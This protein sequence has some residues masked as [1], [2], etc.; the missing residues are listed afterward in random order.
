MYLATLA[1]ILS[2][3]IL[4]SCEEL[5]VESSQSLAAA[6]KNVCK[7]PCRCDN[8]NDTL[9]VDPRDDYHATC[10]DIRWNAK[11]KCSTTYSAVTQGGKGGKKG[12]RDNKKCVK[13]IGACVSEK[14]Q[15][16][17]Q[18]KLP[19]Y[20]LQGCSLPK[21]G[22]KKVRVGVRLG[23]HQERHLCV[24]EAGRDGQAMRRGLP[25]RLL[26]A[27]LRGPRARLQDP[28]AGR[29]GTPTML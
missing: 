27:M 24:L 17:P 13:A 28:R 5:S 9:I 25:H 7:G 29:G 14:A 12:G 4:S 19:E 21:D 11:V 10:Q 2:L 6:L 20:L 23:R 18:C 8:P 15:F 3:A 16:K 1:T 22:K 26:P